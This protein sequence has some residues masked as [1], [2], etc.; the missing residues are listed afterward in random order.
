MRQLELPFPKL[1]ANIQCQ[2]C[3]NVAE[4]PFIIT[5]HFGYITHELAFCDELCADLY[6]LKRLREGGL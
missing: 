2:H 3:L 1:E 5:R 6:Y 4:K